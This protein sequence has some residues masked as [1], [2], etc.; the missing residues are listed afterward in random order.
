MESWIDQ[1]TNQM[2]RDRKRYNIPEA[3]IERR[4]S[5]VLSHV[6]L[7]ALCYQALGL[8]HLT[9]DKPS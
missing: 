8:G 6:A 3:S 1:L 5:A 2:Q 7:R 9:D 4:V